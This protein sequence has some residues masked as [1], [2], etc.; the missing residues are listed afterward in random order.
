[1]L[2]HYAFLFSFLYAAAQAIIPYLLPH[3]DIASI[4]LM[5]VYSLC[6]VHIAWLKH[7]AHSLIVLS[8]GLFIRF[9]LDSYSVHTHQMNSYTFTS[10]YIRYRYEEKTIKSQQREG[11]RERASAYM[12]QIKVGNWVSSQIHDATYFDYFNFPQWISFRSKH[13][14]SSLAHSR[15]ACFFAFVLFHSG[16]GLFHSFTLIFL[17]D[18]LR[19]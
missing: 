7:Y 4:R 15:L 5:V 12:W 11:E 2:F 10:K 19:S 18:L 8:V 14:H 3:K 16:R 6:N 9:I 13:F 1:M 17:S